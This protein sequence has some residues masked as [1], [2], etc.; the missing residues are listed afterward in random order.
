MNLTLQYE[1]LEELKLR[2]VI[3]GYLYERNSP[4]HFQVDLIYNQ[5]QL[6][7]QGPEYS[8]NPHSKQ[9]RVGL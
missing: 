5:S 9:V 4:G 7:L 8:D 1:N 6:Y 3:S 2:L